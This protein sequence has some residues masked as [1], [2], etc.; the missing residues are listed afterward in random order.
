M[1]ESVT[2]SVGIAAELDQIGE[3]LH[4]LEGLADVLETSAENSRLGV[5]DVRIVLETGDNLE[6]E[7]WTFDT[8]RD[9]GFEPLWLTT[10]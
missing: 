5:Y 7:A 4:W 2:V 8:L 9:L 1:G 3:L 10:S 6:A